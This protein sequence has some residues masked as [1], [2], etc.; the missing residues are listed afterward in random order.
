MKKNR[1]ET[2]FEKFAKKF[3]IVSFVL[4]ALGIV[5]LNSY[6]STINVSY[7]TVEKEI[8]TIQSDIDSL[9]MK[10]QELVSFSRISTIATSKGYNYKQSSV[11][12]NIVGVDINE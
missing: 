10:K 2:K 8:N 7:K 1:R 3:L 4:F 9:D 5:A 11:A 12:A 6:E